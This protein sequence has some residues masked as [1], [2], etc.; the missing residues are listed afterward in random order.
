MNELKWGRLKRT[1]SAGQLLV[2][3]TASGQRHRP[4]CQ[5]APD[6]VLKQPQDSGRRS[7]VNKIYYYQEIISD[8]G[9]D[10]LENKDYAQVNSD[11]SMPR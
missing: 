4:Q 2:L 10:H 8:Q 1:P 9:V 6:P 3:K 11:S 5:A 7:S